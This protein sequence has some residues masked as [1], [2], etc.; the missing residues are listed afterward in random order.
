[1]TICQTKGNRVPSGEASQRRNIVSGKRERASVSQKPFQY[2]ACIANV[3]HC[4]RAKLI[5]LLSIAHTC[6]PTH[7]KPPSSLDGGKSVQISRMKSMK[8]ILYLHI[9]CIIGFYS[10]SMVLA[11]FIWSKYYILYFFY[12]FCFVIFHFTHTFYYMLSSNVTVHIQLA[13]TY[14]YECMSSF[15]YNIIHQLSDSVEYHI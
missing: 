8:P 10:N 2:F 5:L 14:M 9:K 11:T 12:I 3:W 1:M 7:R 15:E 4:V 13:S 6:R